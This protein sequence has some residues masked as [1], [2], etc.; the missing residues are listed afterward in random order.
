[1]KIRTDRMMIFAQT[2]VDR[3]KP[4]LNKCISAIRDVDKIY[5]PAAIDKFNLASA[6]PGSCR[7]VFIRIW[8]EYVF[9]KAIYIRHGSLR[10]PL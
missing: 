10:C 4:G 7:I 2:W 9:V 5:V 6:I 3:S 8:E 1:M